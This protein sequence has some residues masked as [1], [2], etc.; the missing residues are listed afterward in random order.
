MLIIRSLEVTHIWWLLRL[1]RFGSAT[2]VPATWSF[3]CIGLEKDLSL[4]YKDTGYGLVTSDYLSPSLEAPLPNTVTLEVRASYT[5]WGNRVQSAIAGKLVGD[6]SLS[7]CD[8]SSREHS[9]ERKGL[10]QDGT[11]NHGGVQRLRG[12]RDRAQSEDR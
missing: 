12:P 9:S 8:A 3:L 4:S 2:S 11:A 1:S 5:N 6:W 10:V 7:S